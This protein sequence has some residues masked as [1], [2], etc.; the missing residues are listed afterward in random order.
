MSQT[1]NSPLHHYRSVGAYGAAAA[2]NRAELVLR[3]MD[4]ALDR[5]A[6][7]RGQMARRETAAKTE[8]VTRAIGLVDGLRACLD[9]ERGGEIAA[10]LERLYDYMARRLVEANLGDRP[11]LL[12]EVAGLLGEIREGWSTISRNAEAAPAAP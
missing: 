11:E 5:I 7:A 12:D 2:E 3:M 9:F 8:S 6:A 10:N 4:G 1:P